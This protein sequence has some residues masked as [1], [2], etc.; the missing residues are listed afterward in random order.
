MYMYTHKDIMIV[1]GNA[2]RYYH[3]CIRKCTHSFELCFAKACMAVFLQFTFIFIFNPEY[4][5]VQ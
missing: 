5:S 4:S 2:Q 1:Y 3:D